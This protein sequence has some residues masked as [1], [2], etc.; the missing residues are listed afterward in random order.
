MQ[1]LI[2]PFTEADTEII[3]FIN[4]LRRQKKTFDIQ[5]VAPSIDDPHI[6]WTF[7]EPDLDFEN[8]GLSSIADDW[9]CPEEWAEL[10]K[11]PTL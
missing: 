2:L 7:P 10:S 5:N 11:T 8:L 1:T 9:D 3:K 6:V 4:R